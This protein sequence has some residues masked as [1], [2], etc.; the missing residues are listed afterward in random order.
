[1]SYVH[2]KV[3]PVELLGKT[4]KFVEGL[5]KGSKSL[6]IHTEKNTY[7]LSQS[8]IC[9]KSTKLHDCE[10]TGEIYNSKILNMT[11]IIGVLDNNQL[12]TYYNI[13]T[14][15]GTLITKWHDE[16]GGIENMGFYKVVESRL[17]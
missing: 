4:I 2:F 5:E 10:I 3:E 8:T 11:V 1:M 13:E 6:A 16:N 14:D 12:Y 7:L 15:K 9:Y 17:W